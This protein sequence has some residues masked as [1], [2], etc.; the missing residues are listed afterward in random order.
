MSVGL[1]EQLGIQKIKTFPPLLHLFPLSCSHSFLWPQEN[2]M[3][4]HLS[5]LSL[6]LSTPAAW[7]K[8]RMRDPE[9]DGGCAYMTVCVTKCTSLKEFMCQ[10]LCLCLSPTNILLPG[11]SRKFDTIKQ[12]RLL[13]HNIE[14][15]IAWTWFYYINN[16]PQRTDKNTRGD[17]LTK[18]K[19]FTLFQCQ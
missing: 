10:C 17:Q 14:P 15:D 1:V 11:W 18:E 16:H 12:N 13:Q 8:P 7:R 9:R 19:A 2:N 5:C 4:S 6:H 3:A